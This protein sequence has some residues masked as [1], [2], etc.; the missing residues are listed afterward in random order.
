M[1]YIGNSPENVLRNR[2]AIYEFVA[3]AGQTAFSGV[4][5]NGATLDLLQDNEQSVFLNGVRIIATDDYTVSGDTLTLIQAASAGDILIVETQ[6]EVANATT[7]T[8][9][10]ADARYVNY[11]G[12]VIS[13]NIQIAGDLTA[14]SLAID[15]DVLYVDATNN[16]VGINLP[17]LNPQEALHVAGNIRVN[18]NQEFRTIDT[19][20]STRTIMRVNNSDELEYGWSGGGAV[21]FMGGGSYTE[22]MRIHTNSN[23][24]INDIAPHGTLT[25]TGPRILVQRTDD[26]SSIAFANNTT[27]APASHTWA[28]GLNYSNSNAFT[29]AYGSGGVPSLES[30]KMV[31]NTNG[32]FGIGT[33]TPDYKLDIE[34]SGNGLIVARVKN[35]TAG[36]TA[37]ADMLVE[38]DASDIRMI[39]ASSLY[40]GVAGWADTGIIATSSGTSGGMAFNVQGNY[41]IRF[42]QSVT[43]ER[44]R[45]HTNGNVG[46]GEISPDY[47][48]HVS[49]AGDI[50][51]EDNAGGSA[52]LHMTSSTSGLRDSEWRLKTQGSTDEFTFDHRYTANDGSNDVVDGSTVL[53]LTT[54]N[55]VDVT[56][57]LIA[58]NLKLKA[59]AKTNTDTAVDVFVYDTRKDSDG[60][61]WR[62]RTKNT[63]WYNETLNTATRGSRK[64]FPAVAVIVAEVSQVSIYDG[65]DPDMPM[66]MTFNGTNG[67]GSYL[68]RT[69]GA[70]VQ[71]V[72]MLN[73]NL[74]VARGNSGY[75]EALLK[76]NFISEHSVNYAVQGWRQIQPISGRDLDATSNV[77]LNYPG[78]NAI[79]NIAVNDVAMTVLPNASI[80]SATGLPVPTIA[81]A[82]DGGI[83]VIKDDGTVVDIT[84]SGSSYNHWDTVKFTEDNKLIIQA[85]NANSSN[86]LTHIVDIPTSDVNANNVNAIYSALNGRYYHGDSCSP[87]LSASSYKPKVAPLE[88]D[89]IAIGHKQSFTNNSGGINLIAEE[90]ST[91]SGQTSSS[92]MAYIDDERNTGWFHGDA[93]IVALASTDDTDI[94]SSGN[95]NILA[96]KSWTNNA[97]FPYETLTTSG[98]DITSAINTTAYGA[99]NLTWISTPGVTYTAYFNMTLNS[100]TMPRCF[101]QT[102]SSFGNGLEFTPKNGANS[103]TFQASRSGSIYFSFSTNNGDASNYSVS[104]LELYQGGVANHYKNPLVPNDHIGLSVIGTVTKTPVATGAELVSYGGFN[105]SNYLYQ[106][107]SSAINF[108]TGDCSYTWWSKAFS[109]GADRLWFTHGKYNT[110][111]S[112]L[113]I[114][115]Y[116]SGGSGDEAHFYLGNAGAGYVIVTGIENTD[117]DCWTV[118]RKTGVMY[119]YRNGKLEGSQAN[120][121]NV[122]LASASYGGGLYVGTGFSNSSVFSS[123]VREIA[124]FRISRTATTAEQAAR[125]YNDEKSLFQ[126]NAKA[127]LYGGSEAVTGLAYDDET[128]LLHAGTSAGRSMFR[129]LERVDNTTDAVSAA[130]S[131]SNGFIVEE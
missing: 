114:L 120:N 3:T 36:T 70:N 131:A 53:A 115:Q 61:A 88:Q 23:I 107:Y 48:L 47:Q 69:T 22:R 75:G 24:G 10:E 78:I 111:G 16:R 117:W 83:S 106:P 40:T 125:I 130:I 50:K 100:G 82:T 5:S 102:S 52:H 14:N 91:Q 79:V 38:S 85:N 7:Y 30:H 76:V 74:C 34:G 43:N 77:E 54:D 65:D 108:G 35:I 109:S 92:M 81:V 66:W 45:I 72:H 15:T 67:Y 60:G 64:E 1:S 6:G 89:K 63:S 126:E 2:R 103:F 122:S 58:N 118:T 113:N 46:I 56:N 128:G 9:S 17:G 20:G 26:D 33:D 80:D 116:N 96:G 129:G 44:L 13:G 21:K 104:G 121:N 41:P 124:L 27:G 37:R 32:N 25:V 123:G 4:D 105:A 49:G 57:D 93:K 19:G 95:T 55:N 18:N 28:A 101:M 8:R 29:I 42:T 73:G 87:R 99:A 71:S 84:N 39:A 90:P 12:D 86:Q 119:V 112:G 127:T 31:I 51:I 110:A 97:S 11:N 98:L 62:K 68:G 94:S 59:I